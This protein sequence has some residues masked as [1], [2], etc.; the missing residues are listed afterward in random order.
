M[1]KYRRITKKFIG[2]LTYDTTKGESWKAR[3][4]EREGSVQAW[5]GG[6]TALSGPGGGRQ[7]TDLFARAWKGSALVFEEGKFSGYP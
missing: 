3:A 7:D 4:R 5:S 1:Q 6:I 2:K